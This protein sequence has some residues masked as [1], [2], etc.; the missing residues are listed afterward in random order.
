MDNVRE[1][2]REM[3][4]TNPYG[5]VEL[6]PQA[7]RALAH[8]VRLAILSRLQRHGPSTASRLSPD[9]GATPS[10]TSWHLRHLASFGLV[11]DSDAGEDARERWW[12]SAGRGF[13]FA[14]PPDPDD[15]EGQ[16]AYR[17][18]AEQMF[19]QAHELPLTWLARRRAGPAARLA[20]AERALQHAR[21]RRPG[22]ARADRAG[23][24]G[25]ARAVRPSRP[26]RRAE[27]K[28]QRAAHALRHARGAREPMTDG[29][30][31][32]SGRCGA[33]RASA[34]SGSARRSRSSA[35]GSRSSRCR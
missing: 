19:L 4:L 8:P 30:S 23:D 34:R 3:S 31:A 21:R 7:M 5:D 15:R 16:E 6:Q 13:R 28:S 11:R 14:P 25:A 20:A 29:G 24:R 18:L 33:T 26:R 22:R 10:V 32:A 9:V 35:T 1:Y 2:S 27:G 17:A 12:E